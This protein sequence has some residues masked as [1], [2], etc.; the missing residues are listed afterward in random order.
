MLR[1][2]FHLPIIFV[3]L[4]LGARKSPF[5]NLKDR[6]EA[7]WVLLKLNFKKSRKT[8]G[9]YISFNFFGYKVYSYDYVSLLNL[10]NEIFIDGEYV[11]NAKSNK[12]KILD[13]GANI[14][15]ATLFFKKLYPDAEIICFEPNPLSFKLLE[16]NVTG[17]KL[18]HVTLLNKAISNEEGRLDFF[19]GN[20]KGSVMASL[21]EDRNDTSRITVD[22]VRLSQ[23]IGN[24]KFDLAKIDVE[25]AEH[26]V[27]ADLIQANKIDSISEY[28]IEYHHMI[29]RSKVELAGFLNKMEVFN[30]LY[31][32]RARYRK[33][34]LYQDIFLHFYK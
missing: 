25:G 17:N 31:N 1:K 12:P 27:I 7:F 28:M 20:E 9:E 5:S 11:F 4:Y 30:F 15:M 2:I 24:S 29:D 34:R 16:M 32:V 22:T 26:L 19:V 10:F 8:T 3:S 6:R 21:S 14:G 18:Q 33:V 23:V 13:C